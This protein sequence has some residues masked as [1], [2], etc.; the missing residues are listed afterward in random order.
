MDNHLHV[1]CRLEPGGAESWTDEEV[2]RRWI[3]V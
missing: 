1:L 2:I 3:A